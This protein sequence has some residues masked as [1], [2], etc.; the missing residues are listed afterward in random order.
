[1]AVAVTLLAIGSS[2]AASAA[3]PG[4]ELVSVIGESNSDNIK[5]QGAPC[6][7]GKRLLSTGADINLGLGQVGIDRL[8]PGP[9][10][11]TAIAVE[12][13]DGFGGNWFVRAHSVCADPLPGLQI[14]AATGPTNSNN[15]HMTAVCP[16]GKRLVG[17]GGEVLGE[18]SRVALNDVVP[19]PEL[20]KLRVRGLEDQNVPAGDWALRAY[21]VCANPL[22]G[23]ELVTGHGALASE[24]FQSARAVC[25]YP[26]RL[27][28]VGGNITAGGVPIAGQVV[29]DDLMPGPSLT[30]A[31][32]GARE[33]QDG[34][35]GDWRVHAYAICATP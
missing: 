16:A 15:K 34:V 5:A 27:L 30:A 9:F 31:F 18:E 19:D 26:K 14:V 32:A 11:T 21:A 28:A 29:L 3:V 2:T 7:P 24:S 17:G 33:D 22:E 10:G 6:P 12:D 8:T 1:M 25:P 20:T 35:D 23:L 4:L 13:Q